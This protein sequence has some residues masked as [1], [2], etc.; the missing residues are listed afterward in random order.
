MMMFIATI[1][2]VLI[3]QHV[4]LAFAVQCSAN[5]CNLIAGSFD[6]ANGYCCYDIPPYNTD[7]VCTCPNAAAVLNGP[8]RTGVS[9][10]QGACN[11]TCINGG[12]CNVVNGQQV[13]WCTLG[14][15][16][17]FCE[18][19]GIS[20]RCATGVCQAGTCVEQTIGAS[21]FAYC[22]CNPGWTGQTCNQCYFT[23]TQAG[24][25]PDTAYCSIGRYFYCPTAGGAP[26]SA[27]CPDG[28]KFDRL[29]NSCSTTATC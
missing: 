19:Q 16:G 6:A 5:P 1:V 18:L 13:C 26:I 22:H 23:C 25:F 28:Q 11:R 3:Q 15:S 14:F 9:P 21:L 17:S 10:N 8:C 7:S 4:Q 2:I 27:M 24:V 12:V 20:A 29:T